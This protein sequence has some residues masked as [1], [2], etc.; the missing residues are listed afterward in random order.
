MVFTNNIQQNISNINSSRRSFLQWD[1][2]VV[3][4]LLISH[5][6]NVMISTDSDKIYI[7]NE[8]KIKLR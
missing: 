1:R 8:K 5:R 3:R 7:P 4:N 2:N 6:Q